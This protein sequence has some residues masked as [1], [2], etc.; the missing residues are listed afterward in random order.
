MVR[1]AAQRRNAF[2]AAR[3]V[4]FYAE[5]ERVGFVCSACVSAEARKSRTTRIVTSCSE[6]CSTKCRAPHP[7]LCRL[8]FGWIVR[9]P[10]RRSQPLHGHSPIHAFPSEESRVS[11]K[12]DGD[13]WILDLSRGIVGRMKSTGNNSPGYWSRSGNW[14]AFSSTRERVQQLFRAPADGSSVPERLTT[15]DYSK[16]LNSVSFDDQWMVFTQRE[17]TTA[18]DLWLLELN[19][20]VPV[21]RPYL[22]SRFSEGAATLSPTGRHIAYVSDVSG[23]P[24][25]YIDEFPEA[26]NRIQ[27]SNDG[28]TEPV[29]AR[30]GEELFYRS[31]RAMMAVSL[32]EETGPRRSSRTET[33]GRRPSHRTVRLS[34]LRSCSRAE[35]GGSRG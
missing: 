33:A 30:G 9:G 28:G 31:G 18:R 2:E 10:R 14:L 1:A 15:H 4:T 17:P 22:Q 20:E 7:R 24:E 16:V 25:I 12:S 11:L 35:A 32:S 23:R 29:W 34:E 26:N 21:A 13:V 5:G 3:I 8:S 6:S 27:V 19:G